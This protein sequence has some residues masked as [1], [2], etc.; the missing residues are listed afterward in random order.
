MRSD[1]DIEADIAATKK[2]LYKLNDERRARIAVRIAAVC[3][4]FDLKIPTR[5]IARAHKITVAAVIAITWR[6]G[7]LRTYQ[8]S[9]RERLKALEALESHTSPA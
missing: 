3:T 9:M 5:E 7:R 8:R 4:D 1:K 2:A 6:T